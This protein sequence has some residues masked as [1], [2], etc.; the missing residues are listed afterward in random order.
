MRLVL[1]RRG[2][3]L[4][5]A[6]VRERNYM[7]GE[8]TSLREYQE[9]VNDIENMPL[10]IQELLADVS[11]SDLRARPLDGSWSILE[12][13]CHLRDI[14]QAGYRV[15]IDQMLNEK[16]PLL[17]DLDGDRLAQ[18]RDYINQ[19]FG[20]A[21]EDFVDTRAI[22]VRAIRD[23]SSHQL[24]KQAMF[25]NVGPINF[26]ELLIKLRE[27]DRSHIDELTQLRDMYRA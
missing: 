7:E 8:Q 17:A 24:S 25:E 2:I 13:I 16:S 6:N 5:T 18:E 21:L 9:L 20:A 19:D 15:R 14:E 12:H 22:N 1:K 23:L 10:I 26:L 3:D 11:E 4:I 27:H